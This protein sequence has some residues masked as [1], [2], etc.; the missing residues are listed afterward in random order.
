MAQ[1]KSR[2]IYLRAP[3][4]E[5]VDA[6]KTAADDSVRSVNSYALMVLE[7]HLRVLRYLD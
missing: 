5:I 2:V 3:S 7:E 4:D 6:L 1:D